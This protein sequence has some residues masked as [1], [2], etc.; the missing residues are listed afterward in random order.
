[1]IAGAAG[2]HDPVNTQTFT[3][4]PPGST[5]YQYVERLAI[6]NMI[7]GYPCGMLPTEPCDKQSRPYFRVSNNA[8]RGQIAKIVSNAAGFNDPA[9]GQ[10]FTDVPVGSTFYDYV[11][12][13]ASRSVME[14]YPCGTTVSE[15]C[16]SQNRP[17]F[18]VSTN[19]TR[20]QASKLVAN[21]FLPDC[22]TP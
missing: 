8:S 3:D 13:L 9:V 5:F 7:V 19:T 22:Q 6:L 14:G 12:R 20:G 2:F 17:Y 16:D 10:T 1:M 11:E 21:S 18:R 15:P 4:V